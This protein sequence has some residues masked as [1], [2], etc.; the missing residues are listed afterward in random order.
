MAHAKTG[1]SLP[2]PNVQ[3]LAQNWN[4]SGKQVPER[5]VRTEEVCAEDVVAVC[6][7]PVVDL[8]RLLD[9]RSS[10]EELANLG[11]ACQRWGFFQLINHGV[12]DEV[13]QNVRRDISEFFK[14]PL[15]AKKAYAQLPE[16]GLE[17]YGQ[18]FVLS[19]TQKLDWSDMM[20]LVLRPTDSR[21]MRFWPAQPPTFRS[22]SID[23][24]MMS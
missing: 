12:P 15:E 13:I 11:S 22:R 17:G 8:G 5:F 14:L 23:P 4:G 19:E 10:E 3:A 9:P 20:Y 21:D 16:S 2:V 18:V 6:A 1:R 7:L 24:A